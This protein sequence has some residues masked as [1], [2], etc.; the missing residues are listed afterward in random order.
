M[1]PFLSDKKGLFKLAGTA[2]D[3]RR[4]LDD[5][6]RAK[7]RLLYQQGYAIREITRRFGVSRR[8]IQFIIFPERK[9]RD[10]ELRAE[11]GGSMAYYDRDKQ[12]EYIKK[13]RR[14]KNKMF[15]IGKGGSQ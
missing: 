7:I 2:L 12:R 8:L 10:L 9:V 1:M 5:N 11:R 3:R 14:Y 15:K 13:H 6:D 4:K